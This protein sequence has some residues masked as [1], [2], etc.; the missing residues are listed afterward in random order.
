MGSATVPGV[1]KLVVL[2]AALLFG[3]PALAVA[4]AWPPGSAGASGQLALEAKEKAVAALE[5]ANAD[6]TAA[7]SALVPQDWYGRPVAAVRGLEAT[8]L[9][10]VTH[11]C[12]VVGTS[13][14][15]GSP[16][17]SA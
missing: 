12:D 11:E 9:N 6:L 4:Q 2:T 8:W 5:R 15:A 13:T 14:L 3:I 17:Q 10:Y 16:W 1:G 7:L